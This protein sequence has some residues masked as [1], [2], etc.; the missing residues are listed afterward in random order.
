MAARRV[1]TCPLDGCANETDR[2]GAL[3]MAHRVKPGL[4]WAKLGGEDNL[5]VIMVHEDGTSDCIGWDAGA[6]PGSIG[7][8]ASPPPVA[9]WTD[10]V[11]GLLDGPG[12]TDASEPWKAA[13]PEEIM[14]DLATISAAPWRPEE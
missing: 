1:Y 13:T 4:Y 8:A 7:P 3:C 9:V 2:N 5:T 12:F 10:G 11:R 6:F 14:A